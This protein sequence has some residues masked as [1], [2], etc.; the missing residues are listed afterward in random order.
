MRLKVREEKAVHT[1]SLISGLIV[2]EILGDRLSIN[3]IND[4]LSSEI[5]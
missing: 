3:L 5:H 4:R 2:I 1:H